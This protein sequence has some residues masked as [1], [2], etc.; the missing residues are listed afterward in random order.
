MTAPDG[1]LP[2]GRTPTQADNTRDM[3]TS[4]QR[5]RTLYLGTSLILQGTT[6]RHA[7]VGATPSADRTITFPDASGTVVLAGS[8]QS[9]TAA[10]TIAVDDATTN[11]VTR[12]LALSHTTSGT[13]ANGIGAGLLLRAESAAGTLRSA[14][15]VDA[16][17]TDATD[18]AEVSVLVLRAARAGTLLEAARFAAP[19][20]AVNSLYVT[21]SATGQPIEVYPQ[22]NDANTI[23][24][25]SGKGTSAVQLRAGNGTVRVAVDNTGLGFFGA[26]PAAQPTAVADASGGATVDTEARAAL[27]ALL[28]RLRTL[29]LI[30]T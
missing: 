12:G 20:S 1:F 13:A 26:S 18:G 7:L 9:F 3:G 16:I 4:T 2:Y 23:L 29:G 15:A 5:W 25:L 24:A 22:G 28:A 6:H 8:A 17:H 30:A 27:N 10:Q 19:A 21:G 11:G 14:G